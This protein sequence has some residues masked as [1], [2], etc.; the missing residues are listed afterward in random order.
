MLQHASPVGIEAQPRFVEHEDVGVGKVED[1][2]PEPLTRAARQASGDDLQVL[3]ETPT[4]DHRVDTLPTAGRAAARRTR[5]SGRPS[6]GRGNAGDCGRND[7]AGLRCAAARR[8]RRGRSTRMRPL[9]GGARARQAGA[10][11]WTSHSRW[12]RRAARARPGAPTATDRA[13][14][15]L[16]AVSLG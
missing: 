4:C 12:R 1:R 14:P 11:W 7:S 6:V 13:A 2:E 9:S 3:A 16:P 5:E 8:Q 10:A 15:S